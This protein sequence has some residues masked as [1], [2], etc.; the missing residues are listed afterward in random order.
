V[1]E[2]AFAPRLSA[3]QPTAAFGMEFA[4]AQRPVVRREE[5]EAR[6][7]LE[8]AETRAHPAGHLNNREL[9]ILRMLAKGR[10]IAE[11]ADALDLSYKTIANTTTMLKQKLGAQAHAD[12][13]RIAVEFDI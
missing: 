1:R 13:V 10:K 9:E 7:R 6:W 5:R 4:S 2:P 8:L 11:I 3:A 12:L